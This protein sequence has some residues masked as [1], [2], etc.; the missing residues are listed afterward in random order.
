MLSYSPQQRI[1]KYRHIGFIYFKACEHNTIGLLHPFRSATPGNVKLCS[2][3]TLVF[4]LV[5]MCVI[6]LDIMVHSHI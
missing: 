1:Q 5:Q 2:E 3:E 4:I 6:I